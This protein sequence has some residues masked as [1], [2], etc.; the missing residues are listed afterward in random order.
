L[1]PEYNREQCGARCVSPFGGDGY[2]GLLQGEAART[3]RLALSVVPDP[4]RHG[5]ELLG[6]R[7]QAGPG[8]SYTVCAA[9]AGTAGAACSCSVYQHRPQQC[10][11]FQPRGLNGRAARFEAGLGPDP[12]APTLP[13]IKPAGGNGPSPRVP[14]GLNPRAQGLSA[15]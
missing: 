3:G 11:A 5:L 8:D 14:A 1:D 2:V 6:T 15:P 13:A 10:A 9:F 12:L 7:S 4:R